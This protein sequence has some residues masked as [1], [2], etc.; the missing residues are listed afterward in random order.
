MFA[1]TKISDLTNFLKTVPT[2]SSMKIAKT[3]IFNHSIKDAE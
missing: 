2:D 1:G 3:S